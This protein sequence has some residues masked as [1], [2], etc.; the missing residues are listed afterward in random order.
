MAKASVLR[1]ESM[2]FV[3]SYDGKTTTICCQFDDQSP[4]VTLACET[5]RLDVLAS[6]L[7][8]DCMAAP[9]AAKMPDGERAIFIELMADATAEIWRLAQLTEAYVNA[10]QQ[11][12]SAAAA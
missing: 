1:S 4:D 8:R 9:G 11:A 10:L 12:R 3:A 7:R 6:I 5:E 2:A